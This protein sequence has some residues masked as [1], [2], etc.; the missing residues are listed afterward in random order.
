M[1][2]ILPLIFFF[3][4][5]LVAEGNFDFNENCIQAYKK[6]IALRLDEGRS[7]VEREKKINPGNS[8]TVLLDNYIDFYTVFTSETKAD[9]E[10]FKSNKS[11]RI[12]R[13]EK[14]NKKSPYYLFCIAEVNLQLAFT[15]A[16]FGEYYT[17]AFEIQR[18][19]EAYKENQ[20]KFPDFLPNRK[21]LALLNI[22]IGSAPSG[23]KTIMNTLIG[24]NGNVQVGI[25]LMEKTLAEL[26]S[27]PYKFYYPETA[28]YYSYV[29]NDIIG[30][31]GAYA[32]MQHYLSPIDNDCLLKYFVKGY[33][34]MKTA[35]N[36]EAI[37]ML[38]NR[39]SGKEYEP[40]Y[41]LDYLL[42][43]AKLNRM[44]SD[45]VSA[46]QLYVSTYPGV[47]N[48]KDAYLRMAWSYLIRGN[49]KKYNEYIALAQNKGF[50][51]NDKDKHALNEIE[52]GMPDIFLLSARLLFDGGYYGRALNVLKTKSVFDFS[53]E[54]DKLEFNYRL[55]RIYD[56]LK[57]DAKAISYYGAALAKGA[58]KE[59]YF[60]A[61][62]SLYIGRIYEENKNYAQA[63]MYYQ[64]C[65][66]MNGHEYKSSIDAKAKAGLKRLQAFR[67]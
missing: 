31:P 61:Y 26:P 41:H 62:S 49:L 9:F 6:I 54:R 7:L 35:H 51:I 39:P 57:D 45:A 21:G 53:T 52:S 24:V 42:A 56:Q 14:E 25:Q 5:S 12:N 58:G 17:T 33:I 2:K 65:L 1:K 19:M 3:L 59:W 8:I 22:I 34:S 64:R 63:K 43:V 32:K 40:F 30:D 50:S 4:I 27:S 13:L 38:E 11:D 15:R 10:R 28:L 23:L 46:F 36:E 16:R 48:I 66:D 55:G 37:A 60:A 18:A 20:R 47:F 44:D 29:L 67:P